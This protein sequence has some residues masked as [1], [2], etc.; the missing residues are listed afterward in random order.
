MS[1]FFDTYI[2]HG[3]RHSRIHKWSFAIFVVGV[4]LAFLTYKISLGLAG[5]I[6]IV[7][8]I[9]SGVVELFAFSWPKELR[10]CPYCGD[11][12]FSLRT[13]QISLKQPCCPFC[14][15]DISKYKQTQQVAAPDH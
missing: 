9:I 12:L 1:S 2:D 3:K 13:P 6:F 11:D 10:R 14:G 15:E 8:S 7:S 5:G 4:L